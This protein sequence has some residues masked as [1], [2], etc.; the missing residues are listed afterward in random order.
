MN[1]RHYGALQGQTKP[2]LLKVGDEQTHLA[3][4]LRR[5]TIMD[6][7]DETMTVQGNTYPAFDRRYADVPEGELPLGENLKI[8]LERVLPFWESDI[9]KDLK[10]GKN[11]VPL[12]V[13]H[14][15]PG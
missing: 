9:S 14:C 7:Y 5:F 3:S 12:T 1:E 10:A 15:V 11:V 13:T 8:T 6:S 4:F 2:K